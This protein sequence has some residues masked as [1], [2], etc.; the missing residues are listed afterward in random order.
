MQED[1]IQ[2]AITS[3]AP[4]TCATCKYFHEGN[5][6]CGKD[7]C[8][9]PASGRDFPLYNGPIPRE[10]FADRCLICG[11]GELYCLIVNLKTKFALCKKHRRVYQHIES[12]S[13]LRL[14]VTTITIT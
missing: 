10:N 6:F 3:G 11:S 9:G 13:G 12:Q 5:M 1:S 14:P 4:I 8:G 2:K 7:E